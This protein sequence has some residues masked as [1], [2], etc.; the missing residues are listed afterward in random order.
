MPNLTRLRRE[1]VVVTRTGVMSGGPGH[2]GAPAFA[3]HAEAVASL[4]EIIRQKGGALRPHFG[5]SARRLQALS[6]ALASRD[7]QV[8][9]ALSRYYR[10]DAADEQL[11]SIAASLYGHA[12]VQSVFLKPSAEPPT[13]LNAMAPSAAEP[14]SETPDFTE[15]Q[16]YLDPAPGGVDARYAWSL[17][18]GAGDR[19]SIIDIEGE[20]R[21]SHEDLVDNEGGVVGGTPP[22]DLGWRNHGTAVLGVFHGG[23]NGF[24]VTGICPN[25]NVRGISVFNDGASAAVRAAADL[26]DAGDIILIELHYPGPRFNFQPRDDQRGYIPAEWWPDT[27]E[28]IRY[29][30]QKGVI[31][32]EAGGNGAEN[33]DDPLYDINPPAPYGPFPSTWS[34]PF[35]RTPLDSSAIVVG[36]GAPPQGTHQHD[37]GPDRSRLDFS[38]Y[39][40]IV[41]VQGWGR[42][43]TSC[44]YGDLQGGDNED[45]WYTDQFSGTSSASPVI[46]GVL[47]ALQG[48]L[49]AAGQPL[50]TP[51]SARAVLRGSG[52][53]QQDGAAGPA[54]QR[55]GNRPDL[56]VFI[57][58]LIPNAP[59]AVSQ[60]TVTAAQTININIGD[61]KVAR[62]VNIN[63]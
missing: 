26:L 60:P 3:L 27:F 62:I 16:N 9:G 24:G 63:L 53:P 10:V 6:F 45:L 32:V 5:L 33:L 22:G 61:T 18:G 17:P 2:A 41:D 52:S 23:K 8:P 40:A 39:G 58:Q 30:T 21:F 35:R 31:V 29:A 49:R 55:I 15:R 54:T 47:G 59:Q 37:W 44:S 4:S 56:Q 46:V 48:A 13:I 42:E 38:N 20:W 11:E 34:N 7:P 19:V 12:E 43:V 28:A 57:R 25:A 14:P 1:L 51:N 50:L 36:A